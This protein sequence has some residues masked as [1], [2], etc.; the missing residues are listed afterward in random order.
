MEVCYTHH[1]HPL[2]ALAD[3]VLK[4]AFPRFIDTFDFGARRTC[5]SAGIRLPREQREQIEDLLGGGTILACPR[6]QY[7]GL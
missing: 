1:A 5:V 2:F 3:L 4:P 6:S 7:Q